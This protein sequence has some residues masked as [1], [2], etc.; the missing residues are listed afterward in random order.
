MG[1]AIECPKHNSRFDI[2]SGAAKRATV[3]VDLKTYPVKL[4]SGT[5]YIW[6]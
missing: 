2:P 3:C 5:V 1:S 6:I 4:E